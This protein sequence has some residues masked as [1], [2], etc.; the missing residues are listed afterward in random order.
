[1]LLMLFSNDISTIDRFHSNKNCQLN[2]FEALYMIKASKHIYHRMYWCKMTVTTHINSH[3]RLILVIMK[4]L[5]TA[6]KK[7]RIIIILALTLLYSV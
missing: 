2:V 1:M 6:L 4:L 3:I 5:E 7:E